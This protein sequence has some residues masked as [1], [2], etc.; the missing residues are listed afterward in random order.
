MLN[1]TDFALTLP[2]GGPKELFQLPLAINE[3]LFAQVLTFKKK[4]IERKK[5]QAFRAFI[6]KGG[7]QSR[8]VW[9]TRLVKRDDFAI[10]DLTR[11]L[12]NACSTSFIRKRS[13]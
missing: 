5:D 8:K 10:G 2:E 3:H 11:I 1:V 7:L 9:R 13:I 4:E 12:G 6:R